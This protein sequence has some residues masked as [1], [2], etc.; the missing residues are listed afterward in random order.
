MEFLSL[1]RRHSSARNVPSGEERGVTNVFAGYIRHHCFYL[2]VFLLLSWPVSSTH[3]VLM[4]LLKDWQKVQNVFNVLV[5]AAWNVWRDN[6]HEKRNTR[7]TW[8]P[9]S[10]DHTREDGSRLWRRHRRTKHR[11]H[12]PL[13]SGSQLFYWLA[14]NVTCKGAVLI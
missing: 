11:T 14:V 4:E 7:R 2:W 3:C 13:K 9:G 5:S 12:W 1:S 6:S 10:D 8:L